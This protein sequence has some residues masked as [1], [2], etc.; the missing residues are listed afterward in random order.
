MVLLEKPFLHS[1]AGKEEP[2]QGVFSNFN[3][4]C[5]P[6]DNKNDQ[7]NWNPLLPHPWKCTSF[8]SISKAGKIL[9]FSLTHTHTHTSRNFELSKLT[10]IGR[11]FML[12]YLQL[13]I[14]F[15]NSS[16]G[17]TGQVT[18]WFSNFLRV[19][20]WQLNLFL[21]SSLKLDWINK[22]KAWQSSL[23]IHNYIPLLSL[24]C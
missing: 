18:F 9:W 13:S 7:I 6:S 11:G 2:G 14:S 20:F 17:K 5:P 24:C 19:N 16:L 8:I 3:P 15:L 21:N 4:Y 23:L 12:L 1:V 22:W 10:C